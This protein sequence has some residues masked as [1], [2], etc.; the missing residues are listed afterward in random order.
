MLDIKCFIFKW[1]WRRLNSGS[2]F[3]NNLYWISGAL[4]LSVEHRVGAIGYPNWL[5]ASESLRCVGGAEVMRVNK[6]L[7]QRWGRVTNSFLGYFYIVLEAMAACTEEMELKCWNVFSNLII[8]GLHSVPSLFMFWITGTR[9]APPR[10]AERT[11]D[12]T[13]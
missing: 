12:A 5:C 7:K 13:V 11:V 3:V 6:P 10:C 1:Y 4:T 9:L 2:R 8:Y